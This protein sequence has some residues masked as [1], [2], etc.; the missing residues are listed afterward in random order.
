MA[1]VSLGRVV[2]RFIQRV[3]EVSPDQQKRMMFLRVLRSD[4]TLYCIG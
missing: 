3:C 2:I 1:C 4:T